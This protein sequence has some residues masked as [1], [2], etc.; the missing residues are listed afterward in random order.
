MYRKKQEPEINDRVHLKCVGRELVIEFI[1]YPASWDRDDIW[2]L[3]DLKTGEAFAE[4]QLLHDLF[5]KASEMTF[6]PFT[7]EDYVESSAM[8]QCVVRVVLQKKGTENKSIFVQAI[9]LN[10]NY[11]AEPQVLDFYEREWP[12][13]DVSDIKWSEDL[14][15]FSQ[16]TIPFK[17]K[18]NVNQ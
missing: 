8:K 10:M 9:K 7:E 11:P 1:E 13:H 2:R 15:A 4:S 16:V 6:Q 17:E 12:N 3:I 5:H 18:T 14:S